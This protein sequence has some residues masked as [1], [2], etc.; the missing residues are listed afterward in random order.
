MLEQGRGPKEEERRTVSRQR[1]RWWGYVRNV[2]RAYPELEREYKALKVPQLTAK[3][4]AMPGCGGKSDPT[5]QAAIRQL[6]IQEQREYE[7]VNAAVWVT[8]QYPNGTQ[9]LEIIRLVYWKRS[10][11]VDGAGEMV[12]YKERQ[13]REIHGE[14][15]K[16]VASYLGLL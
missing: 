2:I 16:L 6:P 13:A 8:R 3:Y 1:Y 11:T 4:N 5:Y 12:G 9:R 7:S 15:I 10:H 14:F